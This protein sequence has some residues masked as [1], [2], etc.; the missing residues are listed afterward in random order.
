MLGPFRPFQILNVILEGSNPTLF[1][2]ISP[3]AATIESLASN[4]IAPCLLD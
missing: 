2:E 1:D 3:D 4:S